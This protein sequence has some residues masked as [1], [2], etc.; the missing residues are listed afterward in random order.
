MK[1]ILETLI[2]VLGLALGGAAGWYFGH[3]YFLTQ[4]KRKLNSAEARAR[5]IID[6]AL[7]EA[8]AKKKEAVLEAKEEVHRLRNDFER[9]TKE[10]RNETQRLE[11]RLLQKEETLDRKVESLERKEEN[12]SRRERDLDKQH[13]AVQEVLNKQLAE[14]ERVSGLTTEEARKIFLEQVEGDARADAARL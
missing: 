2:A 11:R 4:S 7:R 1:P 14:L 5:Q 3:Q 9:E 13:Q 6:D 12:L 8:E 10:R